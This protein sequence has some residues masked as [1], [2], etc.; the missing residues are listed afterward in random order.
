MAAALSVRST[1]KTFMSKETIAGGRCPYD[2]T[3][4]HLWPRGDPTLTSTC[5]AIS[6]PCKS[7]SRFRQ[8]NFLGIGIPRWGH[9][10]IAGGPRRRRLSR[11]CTTE[12]GFGKPGAWSG[13]A[14]TTPLR[15]VLFNPE[16]E[17]LSR[18]SST[19]A[20]FVRSS[21]RGAKTS[22]ALDGGTIT[23]GCYLRSGREDHGHSTEAA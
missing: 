6:F 9:T 4:G 22:T 21:W 13:Q 8:D 19:Q 16:Y 5:T 23:Q 2:C 14:S 11:S 20:P 17:V 18:I 3:P 15:S 12:S 7:S 1:S 10:P